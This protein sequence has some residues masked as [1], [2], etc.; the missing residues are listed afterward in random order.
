MIGFLAKFF[1]GL[2]L[3]VG[4]TAPPPGRN[5]TAFVLIW[6]GMIAFVAAFSVLLFYLIVK[7]YAF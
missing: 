5:E 3:F 2:S 6:L 4:I 1:R 7:M